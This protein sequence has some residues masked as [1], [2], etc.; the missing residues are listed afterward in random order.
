[1]SSTDSTW[2]GKTFT[3]RMMSMSSVRPD[4]RSIRTSVRPQMHGSG[5]SRVMSPVR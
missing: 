4:T 2:L 3:P 1:M 5:S